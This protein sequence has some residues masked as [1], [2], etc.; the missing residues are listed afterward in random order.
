VS[1]DR[2]DD[3]GE[4]APHDD[5][6]RAIGDLAGGRPTTAG[7]MARAGRLAVDS[8]RVAGTRAVASGRWLAETLIDAAPRVP[9]RDLALLREQHGDLAPADLAAALIHNA[10]RVTAGMGAVAGALVGAEELSPPTWLAIPAELI[11]ETL[12]VAAV[13]MKLIAEL[14]EVYG[15]PVPG[16]GRDRG[17]L[18]ARAWA[19]GRGVRA[20][21]LVTPTGLSAL[22]S[23]GARRQAVKLVRRRLVRRTARSLTALAP[24]LAGAVAGAE[25]NR[26][27]TRSLAAAV[28]GDLAA[29]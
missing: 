2:T 19:E 23:V 11:V 15:R 10:A 29:S 14:H 17:L 22:L 5:L 16:R 27:G 28:V 12:A 21:A 25:V 3:R 6:G 26:R 7:G 1:E 8:M 13:E 20:A 4:A 18:L 24:L 9:V